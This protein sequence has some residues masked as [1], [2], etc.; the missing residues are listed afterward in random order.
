MATAG[1]AARHR[2]VIAGVAAATILAGAVTIAV[3]GGDGTRPTRTGGIA[4]LAS[5][6][7]IGS[8][9]ATPVAPDAADVVATRAPIDAA[10]PVSPPGDAAI[11]QVPVDAAIGAGARPSATGRPASSGARPSKKDRPRAHPP[12]VE[13]DYGAT[14][15]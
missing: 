2:G 14:R 13:E 11:A 15:H 10:A 3:L 1:S 9:V 4:E 8:R 12:D 7:G 6:A 5:D